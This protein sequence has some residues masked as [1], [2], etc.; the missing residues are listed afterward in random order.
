MTAMDQDLMLEKNSFVAFELG[1]NE[2][3]N[4]P[5]KKIKSLFLT[6]LQVHYIIPAPPAYHASLVIFNSFFICTLVV[7][8][9]I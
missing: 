1:R 3:N 6:L 4:S 7:K 8:H 5:S 2:V 9:F